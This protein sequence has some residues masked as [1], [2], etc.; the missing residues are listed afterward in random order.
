MK[1]LSVMQ[2]KSY[3]VFAMFLLGSFSLIAQ[4]AIKHIQGTRVSML[5]PDGFEPQA[6]QPVYFH[7]G[8]AATIQVK[9][10]PG[11]ASVYTMKAFTKQALEENEGVKFVSEESLKTKDGLEAKFIVVAFNVEGMDFERMM[12]ITGDYNYSVILNANYPKLTK[13][14]LFDKLKKTLISV[15]F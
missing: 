1:Q 11:I 14:L 8:S 2:V 10:V 15:K 6:G 12:L 9:E 5:I 13:D 4:D 3:L 7:S